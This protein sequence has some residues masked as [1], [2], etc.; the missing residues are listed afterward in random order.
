MNMTKKTLTLAIAALLAGTAGAQTPVPQGEEEFQDRE[1][2]EREQSGET[3]TPTPP[4]AQD[5][6]TYMQGQDSNL[7]QEGQEGDIYRAED[8]NEDMNEDRQ[9]TDVTVPAPAEAPEI[10]SGPEA[11][12]AQTY[13]LG[14]DLESMSKEQLD[15][16]KITNDAGEELGEIDEIV[17]D[18]QSGEKHVVVEIDEMMGLREKEVVVPLSKLKLHADPVRVTADYTLDELKAQEDFEDIKDRYEIFEDTETE[19]AE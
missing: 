7:R 16:L 5:D 10:D 4:E 17:V 12:V 14:D 8:M 13:E 15:D 6:D 19:D 18:R 1:P 2:L 11:Q 9:Q 3:I